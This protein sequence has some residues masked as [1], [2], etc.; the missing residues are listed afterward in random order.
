[1]NAKTIKKIR[2]ELNSK[3]KEMADM[4]LN[5]FNSLSFWERLK[6]AKKIICKKL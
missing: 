3:E 5:Y 6:I 1:M 2:K 4:I